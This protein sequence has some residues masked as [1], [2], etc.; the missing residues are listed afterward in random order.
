MPDT[1]GPSPDCILHIGMSK[2][3]TTSLQD[4][5]QRH[6]A[7]LQQQG[8]YC[9]DGS[10]GGTAMV[11]LSAW[12]FA[13]STKKYPDRLAF[14]DKAG[15]CE[16]IEQRVHEQFDQA[17]QAGARVVLLSCES[18]DNLLC[19]QGW[20]ALQSMLPA[21]NVTIAVSLRGQAS[22]FL[23]GLSQTCRNG[24]FQGDV[25]AMMPANL[26]KSTWNY[27]IFLQT[28]GSVFGREHM[29]VFSWNT[30]NL[31]QHIFGLAKAST[32]EAT[33]A[34]RLNQSFSPCLRLVAGEINRRL[35]T[36]APLITGQ[37]DHDLE[38]AWQSNSRWKSP[39]HIKSRFAVLSM[40]DDQATT[41]QRYHAAELDTA[42]HLE[43][44]LQTSNERVVQTF[45]IEPFGITDI[46][47]FMAQAIPHN[48]LR[49]Q[50]EQLADRACQ[51]HRTAADA[52]EADG[53][54][55][56]AHVLGELLVDMPND[57]CP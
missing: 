51:V 16:A 40:V 7:S 22:R 34:P 14:L 4:Y 55:V 2:T 1:L 24:S 54:A 20:R 13:H 12:T 28:L 49:T 25:S 10:L 44:T 48:V 21:Q 29:S 37:P 46:D 36:S 9:P 23:S 19:T 39:G 53:A 27:D 57:P 6:R 52:N 43:Q 17:R 38:P 31:L 3:G 45:D 33:S 26:L 47:Q 35:H 42:L 5:M 56:I 15:G 11:Y 41:P 8:V 18:L 32:Q 50:L 30:T